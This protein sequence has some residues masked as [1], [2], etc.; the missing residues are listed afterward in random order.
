M[1]SLSFDFGAFELRDLI[2]VEGNTSSG[3]VVGFLEGGYWLFAKCLVIFPKTGS[4]PRR[5]IAK[6]VNILVKHN[7]FWSFLSVNL[8]LYD[9]QSK[10]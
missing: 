10:K 7:N 5:N 4:W 1:L 8:W 9:Q 6:H 3:H 2:G